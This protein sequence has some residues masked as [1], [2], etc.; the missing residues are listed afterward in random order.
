MSGERKQRLKGTIVSGVSAIYST[1]TTTHHQ[2]I[3]I[4][5]L[6]GA[7]QQQ[8]GVQEGRGTRGIVG[9]HFAEAGC[10]VFR[11]LPG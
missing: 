6:N 11:V 9:V 1:I 8:H 3:A 4:I 10:V 2:Y 7:Q 5:G